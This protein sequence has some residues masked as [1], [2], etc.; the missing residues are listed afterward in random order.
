MSSFRRQ[1]LWPILLA[2]ATVFGLL[3]ALVG[4]GGIWWALSWLM[5]SVP[6]LVMAYHASTSRRSD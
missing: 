5:L 3:V 4:E 1:W 2:V 6:L